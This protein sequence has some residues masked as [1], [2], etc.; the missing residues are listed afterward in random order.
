MISELNASQKGPEMTKEEL[1]KL[2]Y[3]QTTL[4][5]HA[6]AEARFRLLGFIP[7]VT[8]AALAFLSRA[9]DAEQLIPIGVLGFFVTFGIVIYDQRNTELYNAAQI[10]AKCL[11]ALFGLEALQSP[12]YEQIVGE[13]M[14]LGGAFLGRP[15]RT[16]KLFGVFPMWHDLGLAVVYSAALGGWFYLIVKG[17][18]LNIPHNPVIISTLIV[19]VLPVIVSLIFFEGLRR[20]DERTDEKDGLPTYIRDRVWH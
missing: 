17:A 19:V 16:L 12:R 3:E 10:R 18:L 13:K 15:R 1:R 6:L 9:Q 4:Y 14:K 11:E 5:L 8:G 2:D 20:L 7:I